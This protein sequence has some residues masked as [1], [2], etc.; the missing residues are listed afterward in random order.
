MELFKIMIIDEPQ[1]EVLGHMSPVLVTI[2]KI[3]FR[4]CIALIGGEAIEADSLPK[5]LGDTLPLLVLRP[6][7]TLRA[8]ESSLGILQITLSAHISG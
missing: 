1:I 7:I 3:I 5:V 6:N 4:D 8:T 2:T